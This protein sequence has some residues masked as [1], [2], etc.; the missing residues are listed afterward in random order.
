MA[1]PTNTNGDCSGRGKCMTLGRAQPLKTVNGDLV[2]DLEVQSMTCALGSGSF[3]VSF[4]GFTTSTIAYTASTSTVKAALEALPVIGLVD[5][6]FSAS[7][8]TVCDSG[9]AVSTCLPRRPAPLLSSV[10]DQRAARC[11]YLC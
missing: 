1:C 11:T 10:C 7:S 5:V 3:Q 4:N 2:G 9:T 8:S 6:E